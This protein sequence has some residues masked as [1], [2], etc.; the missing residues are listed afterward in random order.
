[1]ASGETVQQNQIERSQ[2]RMLVRRFT[3][4]LSGQTT[5]ERATITAQQE[6]DA[7][8]EQDN[9][10]RMMSLYQDKSRDTS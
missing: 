7:Q 8:V 6:Q 10:A 1:M 5:L 9:A 3:D 2:G 4:G